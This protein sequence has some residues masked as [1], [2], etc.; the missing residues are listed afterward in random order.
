MTVFLGLPAAQTPPKIAPLRKQ[1]PAAAAVDASTKSKP[2]SKPKPAAKATPKTSA[3][4]DDDNDSSAAVASSG[5]KKKSQQQRI[6]W[7]SDEVCIYLIE[8]SARFAVER[9][10][11]FV[12]SN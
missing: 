12:S 2:K 11:C 4:S 7:D 6:R 5:K 3:S 9:F 10:L 8:R 1:P